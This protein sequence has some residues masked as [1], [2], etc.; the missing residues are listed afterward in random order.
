[1]AASAGSQGPANQGPKLPDRHDGNAAAG[2]DVFRFETFGNE[3]FWTDT[4]RLPQ[5]MVAAGATP[6]KALQL[7]VQVDMDALDAATSARSPN[8]CVPTP[9]DAPLPC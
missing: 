4:V 2:R 9:V 8:S 6:L 5:G 1:M 7:G 3:G